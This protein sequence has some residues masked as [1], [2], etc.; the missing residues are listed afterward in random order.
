ML[1]ISQRVYSYRN[2]MFSL[3]SSSVTCSRDC[4]ATASTRNAFEK[5][6]ESTTGLS[7]RLPDVR[8]GPLRSQRRLHRGGHVAARWS[9]EQSALDLFTA[10]GETAAKKM[11]KDV[12]ELF[13]E[14]FGEAGAVQAV[15]LGGG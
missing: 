11:E 7:R 3:V 9:R 8:R 1:L 6:G 13:L 5:H 15:L 4:Q 2:E 14:P 10:L 12:R